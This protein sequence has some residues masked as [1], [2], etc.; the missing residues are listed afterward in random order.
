MP[1]HDCVNDLATQLQ[2]VFVFKTILS[3]LQEMCVQPPCQGPPTVYLTSRMCRCGPDIKRAYRRCMAKRA[4]AARDEDGGVADS[5]EEVK[6]SF[7]E[8]QNILESYEHP[9]PATFDDFSEM[10]VQFGFMTL[11]AVAYPIG[12]LFAL[13]NNLFELRVDG[14]KLTSDCR[15]PRYREAEDIGSWMTALQCICACSPF[16]PGP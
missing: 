13:I 14:Q 8:E 3:Q 4:I 11:F 2:V 5:D 10:T 1:I 7:V 15:R 16:Y 12:S 9:F 6:L